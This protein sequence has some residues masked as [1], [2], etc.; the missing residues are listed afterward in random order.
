MEKKN[1][2][3]K[4]LSKEI[5][6]CK[7]PAMQFKRLALPWAISFNTILSQL[8]LIGSWIRG[9]KEKYL[10]NC[11]V[12]KRN[13]LTNKAFKL[14]NDFKQIHWNGSNN[15]ALLKIDRRH[16]VYNRYKSFLQHWQRSCKRQTNGKQIE[17]ERTTKR[18]KNKMH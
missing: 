18:K 9:D 6:Q 7:V 3:E 13:H 2:R 14:A 15:W 17:R 16:K 8:I 5:I 4:F 10:S 1:R 11:K 12:K